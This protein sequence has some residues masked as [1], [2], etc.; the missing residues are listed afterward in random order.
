MERL[1]LYCLIFAMLFSVC[2]CAL[3]K[4]VQTTPVVTTEPQPAGP[5]DLSGKYPLDEIRNEA[6]INLASPGNGDVGNARVF[7][8]IFVGSF[9]DSN[10]D[11]LGDLRGII[12]RFDYLNDGNPESGLSLGVE[13]IW[14]SPIF[15]SPSYHKYDV[16]DYY[17]ID[18][19][20]GTME[21][22]QELI[23]LCHERDV[24]LILDLVINHTA[25]NHP[26]FR[27]FTAAHVAGDTENEYYDYYTWSTEGL[28]G[29]AMY[30]IT[31]SG[32][33]YEGNFSG[34]MPELNYDNEVVRQKMVEVAKFYLD[35][36]IDGFRFDAAKYVYYGEESRNVEFWDWYMAQLR[37]IKPDL[38][39]VAEVWD[40]DGVVIPYFSSTNCFNFTMAQTNGQIALA[41]KAGDVNAYVS[42]VDRY[43]D[44]IKAENPDAFPVTFIANHDT[45]RAA[46]FLPVSYGQAQV[47]ANLSILMPGSSF[48]YYGE[49]IGM[50]GSRGGANTDANRRLAMLWGDG[51]TVRDP[52]GAD[53]SSEQTNGTVADQLPNGDSLYNHYKKLIQVRKACPEIA[54]G[55]F[56]PLVIADSYVGGFL[57]TYESSSVAVFHN[58]TTETVQIDL[59]QFPEL[60]AMNLF[61]AVGIHGASLDGTVLTIEGQTS[62]VLK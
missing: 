20:F 37:A 22:L 24:K 51:D 31:T 18:P 59:S 56:T 26:W 4:P 23:Q 40:G 2:G 32:H 41:A 48:V 52:Q 5:M 15:T 28:P 10:G 61:A 11:G 43:I 57:S 14:L 29:K 1:I 27:E 30:N 33:L 53:Y 9:S 62:V 46:G 6:V 58:T 54:L 21:D 16:A 17:Q 35:M 25:S 8:H 38:Y 60:S 45:D 55:D 12:N 3:Q 19:K 34:S 44:S 42:Y 39:S 50:K 13:G 7:Y 47:A 36:G 49:E